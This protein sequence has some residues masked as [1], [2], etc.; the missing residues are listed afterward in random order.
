MKKGDVISVQKKVESDKLQAASDQ[1]YRYVMSV[2]DWD[3]DRVY[4][5]VLEQMSAPEDLY[6]L[7]TMYVAFP[8][9]RDKAELIVQ[10]LAEL[11]VARIIFWV[12]KRSVLRQTNDNKIARLYKIIHEAVEQSW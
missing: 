8:N 3:H 9:K 2:D 7:V 6:H 12:A 5:T 4:G 10:K 1:F 11:G